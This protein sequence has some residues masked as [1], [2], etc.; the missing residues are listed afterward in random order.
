[1]ARQEGLTEDLVAMID[2]GFEASPLSARHKALI[3]YADAFLVDPGSLRDDVRA[4]MLR[5]FT[6]AEI[7]EV[8]A[9]LALCMGFSRLHRADRHPKR[10][11]PWLFT[12]SGGVTRLPPALV[13]DHLPPEQ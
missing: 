12:R 2:E 13:V 4:E 3:R 7:V 10:C 11:R 9:C 1:V 6:P 5:S 8:T